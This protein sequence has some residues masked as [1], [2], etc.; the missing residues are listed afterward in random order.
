MI[1]RIFPPALIACVSGERE[2]SSD[3]IEAIARHIR[4]DLSI[5]AQSRRCRSGVS[6]NDHDAVTMIALTT[7][8]GCRV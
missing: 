5:G 2:A 8:F 3:D 7:L 1:A 4:R 6:A